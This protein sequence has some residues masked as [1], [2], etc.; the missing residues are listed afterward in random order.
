MIWDLKGKLQED[1]EALTFKPN[2]T[3]QYLIH[4]VETYRD[5]RRKRIPYVK[6]EVFIS[7][8]TILLKMFNTSLITKIRILKCVWKKFQIITV[9]TR[10]GNENLNN[11]PLII[12]KHP[13]LRISI[14]YKFMNCVFIYDQILLA[15]ILLRI[16]ILRSLCQ[17]KMW[18]YL[19]SIIVIVPFIVTG[20]PLEVSKYYLLNHKRNN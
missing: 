9:F 4:L 5:F 16:L 11:F 8:T 14:F 17:Y 6:Y 12:Y 3:S 2:S 18:C 1:N 7:S 20:I 19:L 13:N 15:T 10:V